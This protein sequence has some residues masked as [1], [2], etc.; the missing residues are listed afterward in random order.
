[1][2]ISIFIFDTIFI[3]HVKNSLVIFSVVPKHTKNSFLI[4]DDISNLK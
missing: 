4:R 1:M 3:I 2:L